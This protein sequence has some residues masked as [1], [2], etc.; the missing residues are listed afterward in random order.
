VYES[1]VGR[2]RTD[3]SSSEVEIVTRYAGLLL[4]DLRYEADLGWAPLSDTERVLDP[5]QV[6]LT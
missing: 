1:A 4:V 2:W 6:K 5:A 3:L